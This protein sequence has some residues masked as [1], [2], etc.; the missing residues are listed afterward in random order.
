M[1]RPFFSHEGRAPWSVWPRVRAS[2]RAISP[3]K[4]QKFKEKKGGQSGGVDADGEP[5]CAMGLATLRH[6]FAAHGAINM[7][8]DRDATGTEGLLLAAIN[9]RRSRPLVVSDRIQP[10][11]HFPAVQL[12]PLRLPCRLRTRTGRRRCLLAR[13]HTHE[14]KRMR[15]KI[16]L[17]FSVCMCARGCTH[18]DPRQSGI[19]LTTPLHVQTLKKS[20]GYPA[21]GRRRLCLKDTRTH[22][23]DVERE[24]RVAKT[25][26]TWGSPAGR[27]PCGSWAAATSR[28]SAMTRRIKT[29]SMGEGVGGAPTSM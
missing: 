18:D 15:A 8:D 7:G 6:C 16:S 24:P 29:A 19:G 26:G 27:T 1:R 9:P 22:G 3:K 14:K 5:P 2:R 4:R 23:S 10:D 20:L 21:V 17:F 13:A 11:P 25:R 12:S 28:R